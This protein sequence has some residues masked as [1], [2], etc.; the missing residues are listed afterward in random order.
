MS[1]I[2]KQL[3]YSFPDR[4]EL[5]H[6]IN[7]SLSSGEKA[8]L[9]GNNGSGKSTLL[10]ILSGE[11][12]ASKGELFFSEKPYYIPQHFGQYN[13]LSIAQILGIQNKIDAL[14]R[15]ELGD[16][17]EENFTIL[18]DD[19]NIEERA[20]SALKTWNLKHLSCN[21]SIETLSG[22]EKTKLF[23]SGISL[24]SPKIILMDE[25]SN[26][27]DLKTR[28]M[29]YS[30]VENT[31]STLLIVSHDRK[32]L[33]L[34]SPTLELHKDR[35]EL[36]GG[37]FNF[38]QAEKK[39]ETIALQNQLT[40]SEKELRKAKKIAAETIERQNKHSSR[41]EKK[42]EKKGIARIVMGNLKNQSENNAAKLKN[43]HSNKIENITNNLSE[44]KKQINLSQK[45]KLDIQNATLHEG[46]TIVKATDLNLK[47]NENFLWKNDLNFQ[48]RSGNRVII[49]GDNGSGKT[50]LIKLILG[51]LKP[52][53]GEIRKTD[54]NAIYIDQDYSIIQDNLSVFEQVSEYN[55]QKLLDYEI[56][57]ILNRFL[58][59][60]ETWNKPCAVL[61][62]G[63]KMR[64]LLC[65]LQLDNNMPDC[66]ILDEPTNNLDIRSLEILTSAI[67]SY[68]GTLLLISH[69]FYFVEE[70][71]ENKE[72]IWINLSL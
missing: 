72:V 15:I 38:F 34:L 45:L 28:S 68:K 23:L 5:F 33:N 54:L 19:W 43:T 31:S 24:H 4:E 66:F 71:I 41:G 30:F 63:E 20:L 22:G 12:N 67:Q 65:C 48:I 36:Y 60:E 70:V 50:S 62:G 8:S 16:V 27:L 32:L 26:H 17:S 59:P 47:Y 56:K 18:N 46:K 61:S 42:N 21:Q 58:F 39:K 44:I 29:L 25:P 37:N 13:R 49:Q 2:I 7:L 6:N 1:I 51:Q 9:V 64:L 11:L 52:T 14:N 53:K 57:T 69:D 10:K 55:F 35:I 3:S 40:E